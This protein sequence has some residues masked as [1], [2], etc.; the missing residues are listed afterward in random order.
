[1][2]G[3]ADSKACSFWIVQVSMVKQFKQFR[4]DTSTLACKTQIAV[5]LVVVIYAITGV[6]SETQHHF[7]FICASTQ[8]TF[9]TWLTGAPS[10]LQTASGPVFAS[11]KR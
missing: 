3:D 2:I 10:L 5:G 11:L 7:P 9:I 6:Q 4:A 8:Q 1:M